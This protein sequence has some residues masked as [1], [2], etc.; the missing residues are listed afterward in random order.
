MPQYLSVVPVDPPFGDG[1]RSRDWVTQTPAGPR[2]PG[3]TPGAWADGH[4]AGDGGGLDDLALHVSCAA[5]VDGVKCDGGQNEPVVEGEVITQV[6]DPDRVGPATAGSP[7][8]AINANA[9]PARAGRPAGRR[10]EK[11]AGPFS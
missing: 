1:G 3:G 5:A 2:E 8:N 11:Y 6:A 10:R 9:R 7:S 4:R